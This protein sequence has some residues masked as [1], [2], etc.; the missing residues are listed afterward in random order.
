MENQFLE[1]LEVMELPMDE[2]ELADI[3]E[4]FSYACENTF[5]T[6]SEDWS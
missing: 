1:E 2:R 4:Q 5:D 6:Y 3:A